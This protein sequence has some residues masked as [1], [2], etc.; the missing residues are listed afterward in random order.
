[1]AII[2]VGVHSPLVSILSLQKSAYI[3]SISGAVTGMK[4]GFWQP[5][6]K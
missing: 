5:V 1:M 2:F 3:Q 4:N 6:R